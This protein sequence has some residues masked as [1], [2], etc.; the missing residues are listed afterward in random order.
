VTGSSSQASTNQFL[1]IGIGAGLGSLIIIIAFYYCL[2]YR[3]YRKNERDLTEWIE[4]EQ[5]SG[6]GDVV[7]MKNTKQ[8]RWSRPLSALIYASPNPIAASKNVGQ[9]SDPLNKEAFRISPRTNQ[10]TNQITTTMSPFGAK[11]PDL[12]ILGL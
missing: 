8:G 1:Y 3:N 6:R 5:A 9:P 4:S 11:D 12:E 7:V 10:E 2:T